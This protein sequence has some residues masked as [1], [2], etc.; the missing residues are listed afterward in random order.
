M[1]QAADAWADNLL[2]AI[3]NGIDV[4]SDEHVKSHSALIRAEGSRENLPPAA[5]SEALTAS[6]PHYGHEN[7][8]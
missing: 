8:R 4:V 2:A 7:F 6:I 1:H 5:H 3:E